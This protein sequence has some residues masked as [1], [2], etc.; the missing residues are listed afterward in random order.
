MAKLGPNERCPC[1]SG[2]KFKKCCRDVSQL[3]ASAL[4]HH[5]RC[6]FSVAAA[7]YS[8]VLNA[9]PG[10]ADAAHGL[11]V[12]AVQAGDFPRAVELLSIAAGHKPD[13]GRIQHSLAVAL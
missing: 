9:E 3:F 11:G 12:L 8:R 5:Q 1:G 4:E 7:L 2:R 6:E 13:S 10:H